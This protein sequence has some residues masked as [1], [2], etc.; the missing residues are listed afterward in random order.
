VTGWL[1]SGEGA[2]W[3]SSSSCS[4]SLGPS[5]GSSE[6][7]AAACAMGELRPDIWAAYIASPCADICIHVQ[8][9]E[10]AGCLLLELPVGS[11][12][13]ALPAFVPG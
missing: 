13:R 4:S 8:Y 10:R 1:L 5:M 6:D 7:P 3:E 2:H 12:A 9:T 11:A